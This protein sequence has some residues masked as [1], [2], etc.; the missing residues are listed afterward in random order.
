MWEVK[1]ELFL[2]DFLCQQKG[3]SENNHFHPLVYKLLLVY[4]KRR[5]KLKFECSFMGWNFQLQHQAGNTHFSTEE[6]AKVSKI[7]DILKLAP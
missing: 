3:K 2:P 1:S 4:K 6:H 5:R 7:K